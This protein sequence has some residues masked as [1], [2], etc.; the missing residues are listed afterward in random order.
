MSYTVET[1]NG[2]TRK[3][4]FSFE[5]L[6]L[7]K[8]IDEAVKKKQ[9]EANLK[10]FRKGKAPLKM[11][12]DVYGPQ[13]E[14]DAVNNFIQGEFFEAVTK[15]DLRVVGYPSFE[16]MNYK[17]GESISFD[18][19]VEIFPTVELKD[20]TSLEFTRDE[21]KIGDEDLENVRKNYLDQ[22]GEMKEVEGDV[23]LE[24]GHHAVFNFEGVKEDGSRPENMK[25]S[26]Y[27]LEIGSGQFIPG[28][29]DGM[30]GMK[31]GEEK[32]LELTFPAEYHVDELKNAKVTFEVKLL[33]IKEKIL[34]EWN[35]ETAKELGYDSV[36]D[37]NTK[38]TEAMTAQRNRAAD[39][40]LHQEILE[41]LISENELEIPKAMVTQQEDYLKEDLKR[42]L[43]QQGFNEE[44]MAD[45]FSKWA[46]DVTSK[47]EFQVK[48]GLILEEL[49]KKY[50]VESTDADLEAKVDEMVKS[51][52]MEADKIREYYMSNEQMKKN[53]MYAIKE[54]KTFAALKADLKIK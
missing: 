34:P 50:S 46:G 20:Y 33:E 9:K 18:A 17:K 38:N 53:M 19:L 11:V 47:A 3:L 15:E 26:E 30:M 10:G 28:F 24:K 14:S 29:E 45:Y 37:F 44:M 49:G 5:S 54:E 31:S 2:C 16:N 32:N 40:K 39:E 22:K 51:S 48:S 7:S 21:V 25:G 12:H 23:A 35:D 8:Q 42:N 43:A 27:V 1:V 52:G 13:I 36:E 6:D 41:K 4:V